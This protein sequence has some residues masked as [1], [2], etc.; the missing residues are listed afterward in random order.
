ML[1]TAHVVIGSFL[2]STAPLAMQCELERLA[3]ADLAGGDQLGTSVAVHGDVAV[4]GADRDDDGASNVGAVYVFRHDG[5][6]WLEEQKLVSPDPG[7]NDHFG[8]SVAVFGDLVLVGTPDDDDVVDSGGSVYVFRFDGA[9]WGLQQKIANPDPAS[10][11]RFGWSV[12]ANGTRIAIGSKGDDAAASDAGAAYVYD[13]VAGTWLMQVKLTVSDASALSQ[14][15]DALAYSGD[16]LVLGAWQESGVATFSG[17]AYVFRDV[18]G[19]WFE[20]QKLTASDAADFDWFG[21]SVAVDGSTIAVGAYRADV[22]AADGPGAV[23]VF[24]H[25]G[26]SWVEE[27][28]LVP[29]DWTG[30]EDN[31]WSCGVSG[32]R[33]VVGSRTNGEQGSGSGA[34]YAFD[35]AGGVW[36]ETVKLAAPDGLGGDELGWATAISGP[37]V[38]AGAYHADPAGSS[39]GMAYAWTGAGEGCF[40]VLEPTVSLAAGGAQAMY[41]GAGAA[42]AGD[43]YAILGSTTGTAPGIPLDGHVLPLVLDSY[44]T[45]TIGNPNTLIAGSFGFLGPAGQADAAFAIP[46]GA[47][48][49]LAGLT[50]H[51]A[52]LVVGFAALSVVLTSNPESV[53]FVP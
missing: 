7:S 9:S 28:K 44:T 14:L 21:K 2:V 52:Y 13:E 30:D 1:R 16:L 51:H 49:A 39:S 48:P 25:D 33:V 37:H 11:D 24:G 45:F 27:Q 17:A 19:A 26:A 53:A 38:V 5:T 6:T 10:N 43:L 29:S 12:G 15:G 20:E 18:G 34:L 23:Y 42:Y 8:R 35:R 32:D 3:S 4:V 40:N 50:L 41:L 36:S 31:G 47:D 46:A 22:G